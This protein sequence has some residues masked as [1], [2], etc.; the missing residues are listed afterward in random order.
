VGVWHRSG[1]AAYTYLPTWQDLTLDKAT[2]VFENVIRPKNNIWVGTIDD[3]IVAYMAMSG[4]YM[5]RLYIDPTEW[6]KGWGTEF[7]KLAKQLSPMG[8]ECHTHL[9]NHAARA[10]YERNDFIAVKYGI[11]PPPESAPDIEYHWRS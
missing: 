10:F 5:D 8:L 4:S 9:E 7:I 11:S 1:R 6:R 2:W 3:R